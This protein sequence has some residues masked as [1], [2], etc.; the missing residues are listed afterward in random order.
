MQRGEGLCPLA[1]AQGCGAR[2]LGDAFHMFL[3][4]AVNGLESCWAAF[5]SF[6]SLLPYVLEGDEGAGVVSLSITVEWSLLCFLPYHELWPQP[7]ICL[8]DTAEYIYIYTYISINICVCVY[9]FT[10][11]HIY[12]Y[13]E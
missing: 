6:F 1:A 8:W 11:I 3:S 13:L 7:F 12:I 5:P 10:Y 9:I 2:S 4:L